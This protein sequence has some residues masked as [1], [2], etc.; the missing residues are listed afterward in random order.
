MLVFEAV[1]VV[2]VNRADVSAQS[3]DGIRDADGEMGMA[4]V[5][6]DANLI[7]GPFRGW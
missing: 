6:A 5:Q 1:V 3:G 7:G 2:N 4:K